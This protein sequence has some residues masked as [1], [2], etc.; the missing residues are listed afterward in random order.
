MDR[1]ALTLTILA[2]AAGTF[3]LRYAPLA[4]LSRLEPPPR[5]RAWLR[6]LPGAVLAASLAQA[7]LFGKD[8]PVAPWRNPSLWATVPAVL[9]AWRWRNVLLTMLAGMAGYASARWA[10][11]L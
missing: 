1:L 7:L 5:L 10:L 4:A 9:V 2:M 6:L 3:A 8:A 11:G